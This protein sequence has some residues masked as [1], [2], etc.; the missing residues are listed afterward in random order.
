VG[1]DSTNGITEAYGPKGFLVM[2]IL[3]ERRASVRCGVVPNKSRLQF[4]VSHVRKSVEARLVNISR[5][6]ALLVAEYPARN[7]QPIW[8]RIETP[9]TTDWA[10]AK[11]VRLG[12][13]HEIAVHFPRRCPDDLLLAGTVGIDMT[14]MIFDWGNKASTC[15]D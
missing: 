13:D 15:G 1:Y 12:Q 11:V 3:A 4:D 2:S 6:G 9:V 14:T 10:A 5:D 7:E 8:L